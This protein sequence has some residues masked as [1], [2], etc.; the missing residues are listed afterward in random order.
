MQ[1]T[2]IQKAIDILTIP[3]L[4]EILGVSITMVY[5]YRTQKYITS[6]Y[7]QLIETETN[8]V[9][10]AKSLSSDVFKHKPHIKPQVKNSQSAK[11]LKD[12]GKIP[13]SVGKEVENEQ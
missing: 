6:D 12:N 1:S 8:G 10:T 11:F 5:K 9:V 2:A 3:K 7:H 4:S 13:T